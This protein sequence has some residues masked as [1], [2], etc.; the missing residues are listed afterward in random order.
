M[1]WLK[2]LW[3]VSAYLRRLS[4]VLKSDSDT[5]NVEQVLLDMTAFM[6]RAF[7]LLG[8]PKQTTPIQVAPVAP[9]AP[10]TNPTE[11]TVIEVNPYDSVL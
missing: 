5:L 3:D 4:A 6:N 2:L 8:A 10:V 9:I 11:T 7:D 1:S